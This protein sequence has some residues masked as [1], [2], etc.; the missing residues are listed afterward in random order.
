VL[1]D[2]HPYGERIAS[3]EKGYE[4]VVSRLNHLDD[5]LD[6]AKGQAAADFATIQAKLA[7]WDKKWWVGVGVIIGVVLIS[8]G[9]PVSIKGLIELLSK[10]HP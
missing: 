9:G 6:D 4:T 3:L 2:S 1:N 10:I 5:C 7:Q 8:A